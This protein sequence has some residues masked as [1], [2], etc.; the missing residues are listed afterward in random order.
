VTVRG[1]LADESVT[2]ITRGIRDRG[3]L[4]RASDLQV[5][6]RSGRETH[7]RVELVEGKNRELRRL[8]AACGHEV[9]RLMRVA[10]G[11]LE[12]GARAPGQWRIVAPEEIENAFRG[13]PL[14]AAHNSQRGDSGA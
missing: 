5:L 8:F 6:K 14:K 4:L 3:E 1:E 9:T 10:F 7:V 13:A 12:L 2:R 11:G